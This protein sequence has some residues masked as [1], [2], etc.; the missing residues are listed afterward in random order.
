MNI[1]KLNGITKAYIK[2]R[3]PLSIKWYV[4][5]KYR[6]PN[7][8]IKEYKRTFHLNKPPFVINGIVNT[9]KSIQKKRLNEAEELVKALDKTLESTEFNIVTGTF[10]ASQKD[11]LF[12]ELLDDY[13]IWKSNKVSKSSLITYQS[14]INEI[15]KFLESKNLQS[16]SLAKTDVNIIQDIIDHKVKQSPSRAN[17]YITVLNNFYKSYL[18]KYLGIL[19]INENII[20]RIEKLKTVE[21]EKHALYSDIDK[22]FK[23]LTNY[24]YYLGFMARVIY[25]TLHR[26]ETITSLQ[27]KDF[28]MENKLIN[29]P[30]TKIKTKKK[31]QIRISKHIFNEIKNYLESHD[32]SPE[33]YFFGYSNLKPNCKGQDSYEIQM[34]GK[35][36][37]PTYT[38]SHHFDSYKKLK[39]TDKQLFTKHHTLYG[40]KSNGYKY[41]K[42]GGD[43][44]SFILSDE[45]IIRITGHSN[46]SIL[47]KYSREYQAIISEEIWNSL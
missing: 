8:E 33:D 37:L 43:S 25:F 35:Y 39:S 10:I 41:Y 24:S 4:S 5:F 17:F 30:S 9:K 46:T 3:N 28:D 45:Q 23:D 22:A 27:R 11:R 38:L 29:I 44:K 47:R 21:T 2:T 14:V 26:L 42:N 7:G 32:I 36:K 40:M 16:V 34:F 13:I 18:I 6:N 31:L 12:L 20:Y 1:N 15:R 19:Q